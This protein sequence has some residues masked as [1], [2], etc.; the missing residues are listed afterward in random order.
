[1]K[2]REQESEREGRARK[3]LKDLKFNGEIS[4]RLIWSSESFKW[5]SIARLKQLMVFTIHIA[6]K[7]FQSNL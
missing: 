3:K 7:L 6:I 4:Q 1:M 2:E 5:N